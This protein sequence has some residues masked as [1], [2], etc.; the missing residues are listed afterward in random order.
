MKPFFIQIIL[1]F[2]FFLFPVYNQRV[3]QRILH[4]TSAGI[5][6][7]TIRL[8]IKLLCLEKPT[9]KKN[10]IYNLRTAFKSIHIARYISPSHL[11]VFSHVRLRLYLKICFILLKL[12]LNIIE[13]QHNAV[14][15]I[16][17]VY[18]L[19]V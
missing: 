14:F 11:L 1:F 17:K 6:L 19:S 12:V 18:Q 4:L 7:R 3:P 5:F 15:V 16:Q 13:K 9:K 8:L 2:A 10:L